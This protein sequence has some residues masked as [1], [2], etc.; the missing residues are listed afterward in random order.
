MPS[1]QVTEDTG[2]GLL[3]GC[4]VGN[5]E[6]AFREFCG[7]LATSLIFLI[8]SLVVYY[9]LP[10]YPPAMCVFLA[11][12]CA[13]LAYRWPAIALVL[14]LL[15][16]SPA[17]SYQ[18][19]GALWAFISLGTIA[20]MLPFAL[21]GLTGAILGVTVGAAAGVLM[22]TPYFVVSFALL[23]AI[24]LFRLRGSTVS[25]GWAVFAFIVFYLPF[26]VM[27]Y[28]PLAEGEMLP[29]FLRVE[30][31]QLPALSYLDLSSLK[32][33]FNGQLSH[34][35]S[36]FS[37]FSPYFIE[38]WGGVVLV[39]SMYASVLVTPALLSPLRKLG[40]TNSLL[41]ALNP[42]FLVLLM[43][44]VFLVPLQ[45]LEKP[46]GYR[47]AFS[48]LA[49]IGILMGAMLAF[50]GLAST[51]ETWLSRR[52][53][54]V[55]F[56][57]VLAGLSLE[58]YE[59]LDSTRRRLHEFAGVCR[60]RDLGDEKASIAQCEE[61]VALTLESEG[62]LSLPRLEMSCG[63]FHAMREQLSLLQAQLEDKLIK[64]LEESKRLYKATVDEACALGIPAINGVIA[65][66]QLALHVDDFDTALAEQEKLN[67]AFKQLAT[68]LV[69]AGDV[70]SNTIQ[71][72]IDPEFSLTTI[73]IGHGFVKQGRFEEAARTISEDLQ[74]ID[75]RIE[76]SIVELA[77]RVAS[78]SERLKA[79][80]LTR[81][82]PIFESVGDAKSADLCR[83]KAG[84]LDSIA[85]AVQGSRMLAHVIVIVEQSRKL[86][87][88]ATG[89]VRDFNSLIRALEEGNTRRCPNGYSW[90]KNSHT[91]AEAQELLNSA[92][93]TLE[94]DAISRR[95]IFMD[96]LLEAIELQARAI[97]NYHQ[98]NDFLINY[99]NIEYIIDDKF[100]RSQEIM[101]SDLPM[102]SKYALEYLRMYAAA[103]P[104]K[105]V[106][107]ARQSAIRHRQVVKASHNE[108]AA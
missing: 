10:F 74:I 27:P 71:D 88:A 35:I 38:G 99:P 75:G 39:L 42:V 55:R 108:A 58:L 86:M 44:L 45:L 81:L 63:E 49:N 90:G 69:S 22:L 9:F 31:A 101:C 104:D 77:G 20:L 66:V 50:A 105:A 12:L 98:M 68:E 59:L 7:K 102:N 100:A 93:N 97:Q 103:H 83:T 106:F 51:V 78:M 80:L 19:D 34:D 48:D 56:R 47:T 40:D 2:E 6:K 3:Q 70:V 28:P 76:N 1:L 85:S 52:D 29:L 32:A 4:D 43:A 64:Y 14:M 26:L 16:A 11:L 54:K 89:A 30:Y 73:D 82:A 62:A 5:S 79:I 95:F 36:R 53:S 84:E 23:A 65:P 67:N 24:T 21:T 13:L 94:D 72:E 18:L 33:A 46:L 17:Y 25:G 57:G 8:T 15:F 87:D 37:Y 61:K 41:R 91:A 107:D 92:A 60:T 96:R